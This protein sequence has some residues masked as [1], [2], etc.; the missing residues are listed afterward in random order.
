MAPPTPI[1]FCCNCVQL[2]GFCCNCG[3]ILVQ[4]WCNF[5]AILLQLQLRLGE[6]C[7]RLGAT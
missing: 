6:T 1:C 2:L 7:H 4:F 3:A 5:A